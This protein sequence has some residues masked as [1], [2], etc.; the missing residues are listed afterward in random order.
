MLKLATLSTAPTIVIQDPYHEYGVQFIEHIFNRHGYRAICFYTDDRERMRHDRS[1]AEW[2]SKYMAA[3]YKVAPSRIPEFADH[4]H[5][6]HDV[7]AVV[8]F[9]EAAVIPAAELADRIGLGWAQSRV[10][11][12]FRD[13][14]AMKQ[15]LRRVAP[16]LRINSSHGVRSTAEV[17][18]L[19]TQERYQR[20]VLKPNDGYGNQHIGLFGRDSPAALIDAYMATLPDRNIVMEEYIGGTEYFVNGQIDA[21]GNVITFAIFEYVR[22]PANG[23]HNIDLETI[24]VRHG[25]PIFDR[26]VIRSASCG[27]PRCYEARFTSS[28]KWT[29]RALVS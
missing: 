16:T 15:H 7:I 23:R 22:L 2:R 21:H 19:R 11:R 25:T 1:S 26:L 24:V 12:R 29:S 27:R 20:F 8:P 10:L 14:L 5:A 4:L 13:K 3:A 18:L 9:N 17:L 6:H 28:S